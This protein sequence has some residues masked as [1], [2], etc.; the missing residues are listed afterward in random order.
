MEG[1]SKRKSKKEVEDEEEY[2]EPLPV[3]GPKKQ[4]TAPAAKKVK[5]PAAVPQAPTSREI[6]DWT[7]YQYLV[8][9]WKRVFLT[10][11][12]DVNLKDFSF[13]TL[14]DILFVFGKARSGNRSILEW[15]IDRIRKGLPVLNGVK[16]WPGANWSRP[17]QIR[18]N[19]FDNQHGMNMSI[20]LFNNRIIGNADVA[21]LLNLMMTCKRFYM[22]LVNVLNAMAVRQF[23]PFGTI[24]CF[25]LEAHLQ[26]LIKTDLVAASRIR[27]RICF[28]KAGGLTVNNIVWRK[29]GFINHLKNPSILLQQ[30]QLKYFDRSHVEFATTCAIRKFNLELT[31]NNLDYLH[32]DQK[33]GKIILADEFVIRLSYYICSSVVEHFEAEKPMESLIYDFHGSGQMRWVPTMCKWRTHP[34]MRHF[35]LFKALKRVA[36]HYSFKV[37]DRLLTNSLPDQVNAIVEARVRNSIY[38]ISIGKET[39][40][41]FQADEKT[42]M[43]LKSTLYV[44]KF[45]RFAI[46]E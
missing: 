27:E 14:N 3:F 40:S 46:V 9:E 30:D 1:Q 12:K 24:M 36:K 11:F 21:T 25:T 13:K 10:D 35:L 37:V 33:D 4:K 26:W 17:S 18:F 42:Q 23:G 41:V 15:R 22:Q 44:H 38:I 20:D 8:D 5:I 43:F 32:L 28:T 7:R 45:E 39:I 6:E 29:S 31:L 2:A 34:Y 16:V 19:S